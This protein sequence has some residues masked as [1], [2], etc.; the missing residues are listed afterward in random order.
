MLTRILTEATAALLAGAWGSP[1]RADVKGAF[2]PLASS[3]T[4]RQVGSGHAH[5]VQN[6]GLSIISPSQVVAPSTLTLCLRSFC[7]NIGQECG[8]FSIFFLPPLRWR[9]R[10]SSPA[11]ASHAWQLEQSPAGRGSAIPLFNL[12]SMAREA[13]V[14]AHA[15]PTAGDSKG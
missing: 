4:E 1:Q 11:W 15:G 6:H 8:L 2:V 3:A 10:S 14:D 9:T 7:S 5:Y 13:G 12:S